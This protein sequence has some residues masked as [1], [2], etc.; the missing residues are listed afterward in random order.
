MG[1]DAEG[2][3][4]ETMMSQVIAVIEIQRVKPYWAKAGQVLVGVTAGPL[5]ATYALGTR[6][7]GSRG[8]V[9]D[10]TY[11]AQ[12]ADVLAAIESCLAD[13]QP[14]R[15]EQRRIVTLA[16]DSQACRDSEDLTRRMDDEHSDL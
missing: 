5:S 11:T 13:G 2:R 14:R 9:H 4:K 12:D 7:D 16:C 3:E 1:R 6:M 15:I 10:G 8:L